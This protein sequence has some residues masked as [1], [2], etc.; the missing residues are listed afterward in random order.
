MKILMIA[1]IATG[2]LGYTAQASP[3]QLERTVPSPPAQCW[4]EPFGSTGFPKPAK[5]GVK[6]AGIEPMSLIARC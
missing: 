2:L 3:G 5:G 6:A 1:A 4:T